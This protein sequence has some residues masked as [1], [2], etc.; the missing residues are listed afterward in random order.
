MEL[1]QLNFGPSNQVKPERF[2]SNQDTSDSL[3]YYR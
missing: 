2:V 1:M 3:F